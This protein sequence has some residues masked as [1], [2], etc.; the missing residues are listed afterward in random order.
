M[1]VGDAVGQF[2]QALLLLYE[3]PDEEAQTLT[4]DG[5]EFLDELDNYLAS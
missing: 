2:E 4:D 1:K 5:M 3:L